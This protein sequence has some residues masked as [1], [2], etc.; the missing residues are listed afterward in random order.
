MCCVS[1]VN[2]LSYKQFQENVYSK[3]KCVDTLIFEKKDK[4]VYLSSKELYRCYIYINKK[5]N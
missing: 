1:V 5:K 2:T 3:L 4:R